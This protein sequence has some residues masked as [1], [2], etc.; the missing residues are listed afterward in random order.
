MATV[1]APWISARD[2]EER[3]RS[4]YDDAA[5]VFRLSRPSLLVDLEPQVEEVR[6]LGAQ[7]RRLVLPL[8][9]FREP[10]R[11]GAI[12]PKTHG[13]SH[14]PFCVRPRGAIA[15][16]AGTPDPN[17]HAR[18]ARRAG[19]R[20]RVIGVLGPHRFDPARIARHEHSSDD[21]D[22]H[23]EQQN[24]YDVRRHLV[25]TASPEGELV[26]VDSL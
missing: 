18:K 24:S 6:C 17:R 21:A 5:D 20:S 13:D 3:R 16:S 19:R 2:E 22:D 1:D 26:M 12:F 9:S 15:M 7:A 10:Q 4:V 8:A 23:A 25:G 11:G 14:L